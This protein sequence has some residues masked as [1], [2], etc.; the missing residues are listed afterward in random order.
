[1]AS[2]PGN[3]KELVFILFLRHPEDPALLLPVTGRERSIK[4][5]LRILLPMSLTCWLIFLWILVTQRKFQHSF[6]FVSSS[7]VRILFF[8]ILMNTLTNFYNNY[9]LCSTHHRLSPPLNVPHALF[10]LSF[11]ISLHIE[12]QAKQ[13]VSNPFKVHSRNFHIVLP[14]FCYLIFSQ[15]KNASMCLYYK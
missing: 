8:S 15:D 3:I 12:D 5:W 1:M 10:P 11:I 7:K 13:T 6:T 2:T 9:I 4:L 14:N